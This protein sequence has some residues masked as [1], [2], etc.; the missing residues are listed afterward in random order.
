MMDVYL[1]PA[2]EARYE[3]YCE[4]GEEAETRDE[5]ATRGWRRRL[6]D[7]FTTVV[8]AIEAAR[9]GAAHRRATS[10]ARPFSRRV[11]DRTVCWLAEKIAE[12][13]LLWH[14]RGKQ[15]VTLWFPDDL[16]EREAVDRVLAMLRADAD[17]HLRWVVVDGAGLL[18]SLVLVPIPG[19]NLVFYYFIFRGGGHYLS[20]RGARHGV[21]HV[22]WHPQQSPA[23]TE[24]R[25]A[26]ALDPDLRHR[27]VS[28]IASRLRLQHL[29]AFFDRIALPTP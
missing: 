26:F 7:Q 15:D 16:T 12:Q 21:E 19:P 10:A 18:A 13:R 9:H 4:I 14:L 6:G 3:L 23:L 5:Q 29:A 8:S 25:A 11:R 1:I 24:L 20:R 27:H 28:E 22:E 2:G 17:R